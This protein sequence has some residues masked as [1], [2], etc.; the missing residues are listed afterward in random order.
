MD[1]KLSTTTS[2]DTFIPHADMTVSLTVLHKNTFVQPNKLSYSSNKASENH[3]FRIVIHAIPTFINR[4][5]RF[6]HDT[7]LTEYCYN[8]SRKYQY[9]SNDNSTKDTNYSISCIAIRSSLEE[10]IIDIFVVVCSNGNN[11]NSY[12]LP[13]STQRCWRTEHD[14][15][16]CQW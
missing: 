8:Y 7:H 16:H 10:C 5:E 3:P 4:K 6:L 11:N 15:H 9:K 1:S 14:F 2:S 12:W 13:A